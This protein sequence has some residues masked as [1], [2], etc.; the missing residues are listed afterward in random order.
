MIR[1]ETVARQRTFPQF[2][3]RRSPDSP[4]G[5]GC[6]PRGVNR[7]ELK[8][9]RGLRY[10]AATVQ[11]ALQR[12]TVTS[13]VL[14]PGIHRAETLRLTRSVAI[15]GEPGAVLA[16]NIQVLSGHATFIDLRWS[17]RLE[18]GAATSAVI[19]RTTFTAGRA[20]A[21][22]R[23]PGEDEVAGGDVSSLPPAIWLG[24]G[25]HLT[26][27]HCQLAAADATLLHLTGQA[28]AEVSDSRFWVGAASGPVAEAEDSSLLAL[29]TCQVGDGE[30]LGLGAP[31]ALLSTVAGAQ[32]TARACTFASARRGLSARGASR[33]TLAECS[34]TAHT[35]GG[36][37]GPWLDV[38]DHA[39]VAVAGG[40]YEVAAGAA[41]VS[42]WGRLSLERLTVAGRGGV[43]LATQGS[44][45]LDASHIRLSGFDAPMVGAGGQLRVADGCVAG[46]QSA[47]RLVSGSGTEAVVERCLFTDSGGPAIQVEDT[48]RCTLQDSTVR[49]S[50]GVGVAVLGGAQ[51]ALLACVL[52]DNVGPAVD[53][54]PGSRGRV[55]RTV[56]RSPGQSAMAIH[57]GSSMVLE[58]NVVSGPAPSA[59]SAPGASA[60]PPPG[61]RHSGR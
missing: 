27:Q 42:G 4:T 31:S 15:R 58:A 10:A 37:G 47:L 40:R 18:L 9:G 36:P 26:V 13:I 49:G 7:V 3:Q 34:A 17:G 19:L 6:A 43:G 59:A 38:G 50:R 57:P 32:L 45:V 16:A 14:S 35:P 30:P 46:G 29:S 39:V 21:G 60:T 54:A 8:V 53:A 33:V 41:A 51:A 56:V 12:P 11:E 44:G 1:Q 23:T 2:S 48:T 20:P 22:R 25:A 5:L 52:E 28:Y 24:H 55:S 61:Q